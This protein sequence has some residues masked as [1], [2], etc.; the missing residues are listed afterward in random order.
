MS[1]MVIEPGASERKAK[2]AR[3]RHGVRQLRKVTPAGGVLSGLIARS[4]ISVRSTPGASPQERE[5]R[6]L[7]SRSPVLFKQGLNPATVSCN[8]ALKVS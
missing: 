4:F 2:T 7:L 8:L 3:R 1:Q 6:R 5:L